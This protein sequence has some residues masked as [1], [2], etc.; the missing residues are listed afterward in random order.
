MSLFQMV[1]LNWLWLQ[2][3]LSLIIIAITLP[4]M[5][6]LLTHNSIVAPYWGSFQGIAAW[7]ESS[8]KGVPRGSHPVHVPHAAGL[9][10]NPSSSTSFPG[11]SGP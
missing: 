11:D 3:V 1:E 5:E 2:V 8:R 9:S 6:Y 4:P 7:P 10:S